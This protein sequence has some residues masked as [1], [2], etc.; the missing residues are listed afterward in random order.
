M[1]NNENISPVILALDIPDRKKV[2][3]IV[4]ELKELIN[5]FKVG[6]GLWTNYGPQIVKDI[7]SLGGKVFLDL[8]LCDIPKQ[9]SLA[10]EASIELGVIMLTLHT[11]GGRGMLEEAVKI[12]GGKNLILLGVSV[13]T[14]LENKDL[15]EI[16]DILDCEKLALKRAILAKDCGLEGV[17]SSPLEIKTLR[18]FLPPPFLIVTPGIRTKKVREDDQKRIATPESA[19]KDGANFIVVGREI[20]NSSEPYNK[21]MKILKR[22]G[23]RGIATQN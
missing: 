6:L 14:S 15:E 12:K 22:I 23:K 2:L 16:G 3:Q 7:I 8:K 4:S 5:I 18:R 1:L 9:V 17:I 21:T 20:L 11:S 13:L 10:V 19:I